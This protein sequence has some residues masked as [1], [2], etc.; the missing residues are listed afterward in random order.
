MPAHFTCPICGKP[1]QC[2]GPHEGASEDIGIVKECPLHVGAIYI[3]VKDDTGKGVAQVK[4]MCGTR[5]PTNTDPEGFAFYEQL[6]V[7]PYPVS[8]ELENSDSTVA[9][10]HYTFVRASL[11][12]TVEKGKI[13]IVEFQ[14]NRYGTLEVEVKRT[15]TKARVGAVNIHVTGERSSDGPLK[16]DEPSLDTGPVRFEKLKPTSV[17]KA[18]IH[19]DE[20]QDKK[21]RISGALEQEPIR[22]SPDGPNRIEFLLDPIYWIKLRILEGEEPVSATILLQQN[23]KEETLAQDMVGV[24]GL[25]NLDAGAMTVNRIEVP[26]PSYEFVSIKP[27]G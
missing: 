5:K 27:K 19:L 20:H 21:F 4:T 25:E 12:P 8:I 7:N 24:Q 14:I 13:T 9:E 10:E 15:D 16:S 22:V 2:D 23:G 1:F 18:A 17:Y 26:T 6:E 11:T 3:F